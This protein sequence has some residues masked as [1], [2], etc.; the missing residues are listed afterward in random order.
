MKYDHEW[1]SRFCKSHNRMLGKTAQRAEKDSRENQGKVR[2]LSKTCPKTPG[3]GAA[4]HF[5]ETRLE[6][7]GV[8]SARKTPALGR[9]AGQTFRCVGRHP[10]RATWPGHD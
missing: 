10:H 8:V 6:L 7:V 5:K 3:E 2:R 4:P 1:K 9:S